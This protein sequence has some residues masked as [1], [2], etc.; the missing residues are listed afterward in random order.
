ME[1]RILGPVE[2]WSAG[3]QHHIGSAKERCILVILLLSSGTLVPVETL[4]D[5]TWDTN[6]PA[7]AAQDLSV[8]VSRLKKRLR[9]VL[10]DDVQL[11][12]HAHGYLLDL[13]PEAV[14]LCRFRRLRQEAGAAAGAGD[15]QRAISL[16]RQAEDLWKG[17]AFGGV[18]GGAWIA[19]M[20][21]SLDEERREATLQRIELELAAGRHASLLGELRQLRA[22][23]PLDEGLAAHEMTALHLS[24]RRSDALALYRE[25]HLRL[26]RD[27]GT[28]PGPAL[29]D[30]HQR[31]LAGDPGLAMPSSQRNSPDL[32]PPST[33]PPG[34]A[35]F[36][37]RS[38]ELESLRSASPSGAGIK[39][40][41]GMPGVGKTAL[42]V[43]AARTNAGLYP[44]GQLYLNLHGHDPGQE[45]LRP[46]DAL[47]RLLRMIRIPAAVIS[48]RVEERSL[49]WIMELTRR[50]MIVVLDDVASEE[51]IQPL[52]P[53]TGDSLIL[54]TSR[55][56]LSRLRVPT[57]LA[58]EVLPVG[59]AVTLFTGACGGARSYEYGEATRAVRLCGH[60][61][62]AIHL[63]ASKLREDPSG[64]LDQLFADLSP[65][66][67]FGTGRTVTG[68][69]TR[70]F[71]TTYRGL[72]PRQQ[73]LF[74]LLGAQPCLEVTAP[75]VA[76]L[77]G[78]SIAQAQRDLAALL[79]HHLLERVTSH[80]FR[81]HDLIRAYAATL[82]ALEDKAT[83]LRQSLGRLMNFYLHAASRC[84]RV[85]HPDRRRMT[86]VIKPVTGLDIR[87]ET[88]D[89]ARQWLEE[90][91]RNI[92][93]CARYAARHEWKQRC[94][95]LVHVLAGFL[96]AQA[97]WDEAAAA[98]KL[99]LS[100]CRG[101]GSLP[102]IAQELL[103][104]SHVSQQTG[105]SNMALPLA[106]E[107]VTIYRSL[108]DK[109]GEADALNRLGLA[110]CY[111]ANYREALAHLEEAGNIYQQLGDRRGV[112][113]TLNHIGQARWYLGR[114]AEALTSF[115]SAL[116][117]YRSVGDRR[118][119]ARLL[120][121]IGDLLRHRGYHRDAWDHYQ[122]SLK[123]FRE[124][125]GRWN[126]AILFSNVGCIHLY[127]GKY[128][129][130]L[131]EFRRA[132]VIFRDVSDLR[133]QA[134]SLNEIGEAC[135]GL[136][137]YEEA[138]IYHAQAKAVA[139]QCG[140]PHTLAIVH[141][142]IADTQRKSGRHADASNNYLTSIRLA[143]EITNPYEE[144][145]ALE[146]L[147]EIARLTKGPEAAR[148]T[149]RQAL[150]IYEQI[151]VPEA[152]AV[153]V[154]IEILDLAAQKSI[155]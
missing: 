79:D 32:P 60:L 97:Y 23:Y 146:G 9:Q 41:E 95:E 82:S 69:L 119:E 3:Q 93:R 106:E 143:R 105:P 55:R 153:R 38:D 122:E 58:L 142:G 103:E 144:A 36:V 110:Y 120:N 53:V 52:L 22:Q 1:F 136:E 15:R 20:R 137:L 48:R 132:L 140:D 75:A 8:Y 72:S 101:L 68:H 31:I 5:R 45:P 40:I 13:D 66:P 81:S 54:I 35:N 39:I 74:R 129:A 96:E 16:L 61:P 117:L 44:G 43:Q 118:N 30:H 86:L 28:E 33:L 125:G 133:H 7:K 14:D 78:E 84:D 109:A 152:E 67:V 111:S 18:S 91:W 85:L 65:S 147:A 127:K 49:Q 126:L 63:V 77:T 90:E 151:G 138:F 27:L 141:R 114:L 89:Q 42:A 10:G 99:A 46:A 107:S 149:L 56:R 92:L 4:I 83:D 71:E 47:D 50:R 150:D 131:A 2:L 155:S 37:G 87:V 11:K 130:A 145:K 112:A 57:V 80:R 135:Q 94:I 108:L 116:A 17:P 24:G 12:S 51:Q 62:L 123:I 128:E 64:D 25:L 76:A 121:N 102:W 124:I 29:F 115:Q 104:L 100:E 70:V 21:S 88:Q 139:D 134:T 73:R 154:R 113:G 59:D 98:H 34:P 148:I 6:P 19:R 26:R